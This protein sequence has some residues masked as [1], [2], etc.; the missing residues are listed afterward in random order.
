MMAIRMPA[1]SIMKGMKTAA[2]YRNGCQGL[3][4]K[5]ARHNSIHKVH[6]HLQQLCER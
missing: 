5:V 2:A 6:G 1:A 4:R 3:R